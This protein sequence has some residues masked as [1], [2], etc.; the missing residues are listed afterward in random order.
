MTAWPGHAENSIPRPRFVTPGDDLG[1]RFGCVQQVADDLVERG[2]TR[3]THLQCEGVSA[4]V[5]VPLGKATSTDDVHGNSEQGL[6][7]SPSS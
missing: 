6:E 7:I 3:L 4:D 5:S 1:R 2:A